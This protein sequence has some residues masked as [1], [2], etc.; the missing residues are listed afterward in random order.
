[1][2]SIA[3]A[4]GFFWETLWDHP[5]NR[6]LR[7]ARKTPN[8]LLPGDR[9]TVPLLRSRREEG[10]TGRVHRFRR[11]GV[12]IKLA[13]VV[14]LKDGTPLKRRAYRLRIGDVEYSGHSD[15]SGKIERYVSPLA[16]FGELV[17]WLRISGLPPTMQR[18]LVIGDVDPV[19][20]A[21]GMCTRLSA[22]AY[23]AGPEE[24]PYGESFREALRSYQRD[25]GI[26]VT[27]VVDDAT[28]TS[29]RQTFGV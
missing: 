1:M 2:V 22:L 18:M 23:D 13:V 16:R 8:V 17:V 15:D 25:H 28:I 6:E 14:R 9:V 3:A 7:D 29:M 26:A 5:D 27:G 19:E 4:T 24:G 21:R 11:R 12:P 20:T 10:E